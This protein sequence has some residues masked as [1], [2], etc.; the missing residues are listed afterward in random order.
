MARP[1]LYERRGERE[2]SC[3]GRHNILPGMPEELCF[4]RFW[5]EILLKNTT[6]RRSD[7]RVRK[8]CREFYT[9]SPGYVFR[10]VPIQIPA[11][12]LMGI[13]EENRR[14]LVP[15]RKPCYG[16]SLYVIMSDGWEMEE[17]RKG[18]SES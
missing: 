15:F 4:N 14:L 11:P 3:P 13:D 17:I 18:L 8:V 5:S 9:I 2:D 6:P 1:Y 12:M 10:G 7:N 16:L